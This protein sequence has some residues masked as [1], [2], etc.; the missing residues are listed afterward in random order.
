M[1]HTSSL[2]LRSSKSQTFE[3]LLKVWSFAV[4][5]VYI[6][7]VALHVVERLSYKWA[8]GW[9]VYETLHVTLFIDEC[10]FFPFF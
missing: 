5:A 1:N 10:I 8:D 2:P 6:F 9:F 7:C 3:T 4:V